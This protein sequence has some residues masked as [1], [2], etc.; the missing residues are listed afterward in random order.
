M[1]KRLAH[2]KVLP[3]AELMK[4]PEAQPFEAGIYFLWRGAELLY[5]GKSQHV[6]ERMNRQ[7]RD[8]DYDR[9]QQNRRGV[10]FDRYTCLAVVEE[11]IKL[12]FQLQDLERAYI[13]TYEPSYNHTDANGGT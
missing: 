10:P 7:V 9:L 12:K 2:I 1:R 11:G 8:R 5:I 4:L 13:A 3:L 6:L